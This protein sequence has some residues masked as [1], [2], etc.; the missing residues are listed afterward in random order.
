[1]KNVFD[2][3]DLDCAVCAAKMQEAIA[4]IEGVNAV[5]VNFIAQKLMLDYDETKEKEILKKVVKAIKKVEPDCRV[6]GI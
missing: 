3:I 6:A 5:E 4:K 1:M 2:L